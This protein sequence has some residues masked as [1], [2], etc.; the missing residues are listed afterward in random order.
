MKMKTLLSR[1]FWLIVFTWYS[2]FLNAQVNLSEGLVAYYPFNGNPADVSGNN[3]NGTAFGT[4]SYITDP[5]GNPGS[6]VSFG[7]HTNQGRISVNHSA[8]LNF[9]TGAS[10]SFWARVSSAVGI[11]GNGNPGVGGSHCFFA[12]AGDAGGGFWQLSRIEG[13]NTLRHQI[14][15]NSVATLTADFTPYA[16]N[17]WV[18]YIVTM[19][20][21]GH[22]TYVNGT[23]QASNDT[24]ANFTAMVNRSLVIGR[25]NSNWY[26][27]NGAIDEFRVYNRVLSQDE[28]AA[29]A[30]NEIG[31]VSISYANP[32]EVCA[33]SSI[34]VSYQATGSFLSTNQ[35]Q[36]QLS[37]RNGSF[38]NPIVLK[39]IIGASV[40]ET[41]MVQL[42]IGLPS[43]TQYTIRLASTFP[44]EFSDPGFTFTINGTTGNIPDPAL[45]TYV[46]HVNG[47]D[48][49]K[50]ITAQ[51]W[52]NA[53]TICLNNGGHLA[54]I[55]NAEVN[56]LIFENAGNGRVYIGLNDIQTEGLFLWEN[57]DRLSYTNWA[58]GQPDNASNEDVVELRNDN[59]QWNDTNGTAAR[60][61]FLELNPAGVN[62]TVCEGS[63]LT[64]QAPTLAGA[65]YTWTGPNGFNSTAPSPSLNAM[66]LQQAGTYTLQYTFNGCTSSIYNTKVGVVPLPKN[67]GEFQELVPSVN[68]GLQLHLPMNG[69]ANDVSGNNLNGTISGGVTPI[70]DRFGSENAALQCNGTTGHIVLPSGMYF[71]G[72]DFTVSAWVRKVANNNWSRLFDFGNGQA[73]QNVLLGITNATTGRP[74]TQIFNGTVG[75]PVVTSTQVLPNNQWQMLTYTWSNGG[76]QLFINGSMVAQGPQSTPEAVVRNINYIGRSNWNTD[77]YANAGF[78]DFRIYNRVLTSE[79]I[80]IL[81][82]EQPSP[83]QAVLDTPAMCSGQTN[84]IFLENSQPGMTYQLRLNST[85]ANVGTVQTGTG[86]TLT[87]NVGTLNATTDFHFLIRNPALA[88]SELI[89]SIVTVPVNELP[90]APSVIGDEVCNEGSMTLQ[91]SGAPA[92]GF[93]NWY[94]TATGGSPIEGQTGSTFTT[95]TLNVTRTYFV[96]ITN[97]NG[98]EGPRA[99]VVAQVTNPFAP[100]VDLKTG[101]LLHSRLDGN[102]LDSSGNN[103][104]GGIS[105]SSSSYVDDRNGNPTSALNLS[106]NAFIDYGNPGIVQ[107]LSNQVTISLWIKQTPSNFGFDTPLLNKWQGNGLYL[108]LD[109]YQAAPGQVNQNRV[110]WRVNSGTVINSNTNVLHNQWHHIAVTYNG[111]QLRIYQNGILTGQSN[112]NGTI[113]NTI[114]NLQFGRQANGIGNATYRGDVDEI[115]LYNRALSLNEVRTLFNNESVAFANTPLCDGEGDLSLTT[116]DFPGASYQWT[117]PNGFSSTERNPSIIQE[118]DADT[119]AGEYTLVV[120]NATGCVSETQTVQVVINPIPVAPEVQNT[121]VCGSGNAI[122]EVLNPPAGATFRWYTVEEGGTPIAGATGPTLQ[123]NNVTQETIRFVSVVQN[124]C[125]G[126]RVPVTAFYFSNVNTS[127]N[128]NGSSVCQSEALA[129]IEIPQSETGVLYQVFLGNT[130]VSESVNG[131]GEALQIMVNANLLS[132]GDNTVTIR[133]NFPNC[134]PVDMQQQPVITRWQVTQP[135]ISWEGLLQICEGES[136]MLTASEG[137][138]YSWST[139]TTTQSITISQ[140]GT[141]TVTVTDANGCQSTSE[142]VTVTVNPVPQPVLTVNGETQLC[143]GETTQLQASGG[144]TYIW[145]NGATTPTITVSQAGTYSFT[146]FNGTCEATSTEVTIIINP[147]PNPV[148]TVDGSLELCSG[149]TTVLNAS[150]GTTYLWSSGATGSSITVSEAGMYSVTAFNGTCEATSSS[151]TLTVTSLPETPQNIIGNVQVCENSEQTYTIP[152]VSGATSY[153]WIVPQGWSGISTTNSITVSAGISGGQIRVRAIN[154]CGESQEQVLNVAVIEVDTSVTQS[155]A[156]LAALATSASYQWYECLSNQPIAGATE[157][158]Y[159]AAVDGSYKV[160]VTQNGCSEFSECLIVNTLSTSLPQAA[161]NVQAYPNPAQQFINVKITPAPLETIQISLWNLLGQ[162]LSRQNPTPANDGVY[163]LQ[164]EQLPHGTY[165][166][167][168]QSEGKEHILPFLKN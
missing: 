32:V 28:I 36:V 97:E 151:V 141:F 116:F 132:T 131:T 135:T 134:G 127:L 43:G 29:L 8:S 7:G 14:G 57:R 138:S 73:N 9:S 61:Y 24:P 67:I 104:N 167:K 49:F 121:T 162:E 150:G 94:T 72:T 69:N 148:I 71:N 26:P 46:G 34:E 161:F 37:D 50:S 156:Q 114:T 17:Q 165:F 53:R 111:A 102:V 11:F 27:L 60:Q 12:K 137:Q 16:L 99:P 33:G 5:F 100:L 153:Q 87:F 90:V 63:N 93:Y 122:L 78:D 113:T 155:G 42:P 108:G 140:P 160:L 18:H 64:L 82:A 47:R 115:K 95:P 76:G 142:Q 77:A 117:G 3:N 2:F 30:N 154:T 45:F 144:T 91:V 13:G 35:F 106:N 92:G 166:I 83:L 119:Y 59:G 31:D 159:V 70:T 105:G 44:Q 1:S 128:I 96:S 10:F 80:R 58:S 145:S 158:V 143:S 125:E 21:D 74:A 107:Q 51:T 147:T 149:E 19:D 48:Y 86:G 126:P 54:T 133:A 38:A 124:N 118:A 110:R 103:L 98:C 40:N 129:M 4:V 101:L 84:N 136:L 130:A 6:A 157:A 52:N 15:N 139:G 146:A 55:P 75:G 109:S 88:C 66:T 39:R 23:L 79:E 25:F 120:T 62:K 68:Q 152:A 22:R 56:Q 20:A 41:S 89:S 81:T 112:H 163:A 85:N 65:T 123:I 168:L 164:V